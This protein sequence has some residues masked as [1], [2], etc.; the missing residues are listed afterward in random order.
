[1]NIGNRALKR[2]S[3]GGGR[4]WGKG[5]GNVAEERDDLGG[6]L[7]YKGGFFNEKHRKRAKGTFDPLSTEL[8]QIGWKEGEEDRTLAW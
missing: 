1:M 4:L 8:S 5:S 7:R 2:S 3:G 6:K